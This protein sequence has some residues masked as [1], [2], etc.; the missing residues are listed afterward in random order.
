MFFLIFFRGSKYG[1]P[2]LLVAGLVS[3]A[4]GITIGHVALD[5]VGAGLIVRGLILWITRKRRS[6]QTSEAH[7]TLQ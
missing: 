2:V 6:Q 4:I 5:V 1:P 7:Q 3:L